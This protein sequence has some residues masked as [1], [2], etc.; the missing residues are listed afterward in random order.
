MK[1]LK[2]KLY[3]V[4]VAKREEELSKFYGDRGS[5]SWGNQIR[6]YVVHP[7]QMVKDLRTGVETSN[8]T[9]VLD[10]ALDPFINEYL[11]T[12]RRDTE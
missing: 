11:K 3:Q 6:S 8:V 4:E 7:Y 5:I 9:A 1:T 10:G 2:S 12:R